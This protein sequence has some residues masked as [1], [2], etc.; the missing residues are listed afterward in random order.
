[1]NIH[2]RKGQGLTEYGIILLLVV[3]I[4][5]TIFFGGDIRGQVSTLYSSANYKLKEISADMVFDINNPSASM[6]SLMQ[7]YRGIGKEGTPYYAK[8]RNFKTH[9]DAAAAALGNDLIRDYANDPNVDYQANYDAS[10]KIQSLQLNTTVDG[11]ISR[12]IEFA[13]G[14]KYDI[15][16]ATF[17]QNEA[18][19]RDENVV[20][21]HV[22]VTPL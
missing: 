17:N 2:S 7:A 5:S 12:Y 16:N 4:G 6:D 10:G 1:M 3:L 15:T 8:G 22:G 9:L 13:D 21:N 11:K 18:Y 19:Q 20:K 14:A